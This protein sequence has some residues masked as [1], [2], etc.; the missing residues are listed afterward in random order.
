MLVGDIGQHHPV[1]RGQ[2]FDL[3]EK[4]GKMAVAE[5]TE[6]QRQKGDYKRFVE[7]LVAGDVKGA[8]E[9]GESDG[10]GL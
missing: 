5:V 2:A 10:L 3:L 4:S 9:P 1:E 8:I 7:L 6:I